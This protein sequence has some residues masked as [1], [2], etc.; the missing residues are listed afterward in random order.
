MGVCRIY[1]PFGD[2][3][4]SRRL[5]CRV[6]VSFVVNGSLACGSSLAHDAP[7]VSGHCPTDVLSIRGCVVIK[8]LGLY[9]LFKMSLNDGSGLFLD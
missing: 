3:A 2:L 7:L 9:I 5:E 6:A 1:G 8:L 4:A